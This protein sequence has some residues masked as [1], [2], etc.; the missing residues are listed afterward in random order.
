[1]EGWTK[2]WK[3][4]HRDGKMAKRWMEGTTEM[5]GRTKRK[6]K[7]SNALANGEI[8]FT[9]RKVKY[10]NIQRALHIRPTAATDR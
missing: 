4:G 6:V 7:Y 2:R 10:G 5:E 9:M 3:E 1:M 8:W